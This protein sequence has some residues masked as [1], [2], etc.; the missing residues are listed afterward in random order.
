MSLGEANYA[1]CAKACPPKYIESRCNDAA[2]VITPWP[3]L[4]SIYY[5]LNYIKPA[6]MIIIPIIH[7]AVVMS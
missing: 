7:N 5:I 3:E 2:L 1:R 4:V 6:F